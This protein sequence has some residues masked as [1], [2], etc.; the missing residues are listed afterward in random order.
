MV[1]DKDLSMRYRI[2]F[3]RRVFPG[4]RYVVTARNPLDRVSSIINLPR[5]TAVHTRGGDTPGEEDSQDYWRLAH[6]YWQYLCRQCA[7]QPDVHLAVFEEVNDGSEAALQA[8]FAFLGLEWDPVAAAV[9]AMRAA[10]HATPVGR[11]RS[12]PAMHA[13]IDWWMHTPGLD[14]SL[15]E[16]WQQDGGSYLERAREEAFRADHR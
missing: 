7:P 13:L 9:A 10:F 4:A 3:Y 2:P 1:G 16:V 11:W 14:T 12:D 6:G 5:G 15:L 8:V